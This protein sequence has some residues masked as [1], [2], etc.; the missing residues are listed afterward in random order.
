MDMAGF[1]DAFCEVTLKKTS[2][3]MPNV[4]KTRVIRGTTQPTWN[5]KH[6]IIEDLNPD[7]HISILVRDKDG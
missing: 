6:G 5:Y 7:S 2:D 4:F 1:S 3:L